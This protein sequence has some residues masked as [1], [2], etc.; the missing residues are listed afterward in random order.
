MELGQNPVTVHFRLLLR[1][2]GSRHLIF[3]GCWLFVGLIGCSPHCTGFFLSRMLKCW[4]FIRAERAQWEQKTDLPKVTWQMIVQAG[5]QLVATEL[6][7]SR[8]QEIYIPLMAT[9]KPRVDRALLRADLKR[10]GIQG[11]LPAKGKVSAS[12]FW[13]LACL[14][15]MGREPALHGECGMSAHEI[16]DTSSCLLRHPGQTGGRSP[17]RV[18]QAA[19]PSFSPLFPFL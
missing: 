19:L 13:H 15:R 9:Q 8:L 17:R 16:R 12:L 10:G 11:P 1:P 18:A 4:N 3:S 14:W 7:H 6:T 2:A 5:V